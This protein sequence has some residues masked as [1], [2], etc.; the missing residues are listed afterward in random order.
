MYREATRQAGLERL[1][2]FSAQM[3][4]DYVDR[5][6][7][8]F[9]PG[10]HDNVSRLSPYVRHRLVLE[11]EL[12][13]TALGAHSFRAADKFIQEVT[14]RTYWKGWL[15]MRPS[16]WRDYR[17]AVARGRERAREQSRLADR[18]Q[19]ALA[20]ETGIEP[21]D[22]WTRELID[23]GYLHNHARMWFASIW[24]FTL[25]LPWSLGA[26]FFLRYL[27]DG[28]PASNT[29]SWRWVAGLQTPGK[30]YLARASNIARFTDGRFEDVPA[31]ATEARPLTGPPLPDPVPL[32]DPAAVVGDE[33]SIL[34]L[35]DDDLNPESLSIGARP[36]AIAGLTC[37]EARSDESVGLRVR[38]FATQALGD[39]LARA[40][41][42]FECPATALESE[43]AA[44]RLAAIA[45]EHGARQVVFPWSPVG[46]TAER[47]VALVDALKTAGI[48]CARVRRD[49]D[50]AFWP[51]ATR[52]YFSFRKKVP[53]VLADLL[54]AD[55]P[56]HRSQARTGQF[57]R[58]RRLR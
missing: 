10:R 20:G 18:L 53:S 56:A 5:R 29:L 48:R 27:V 51:H 23:T 21:F 40:A 15:E 25:K 13:E 35:H 1:A 44:K 4:R 57:G 6:N 38:D 41:A 36:V 11:S 2:A 39:G 43:N 58:R 3:G 47:L 26:D 34:V 52:G 55:V 16:M 45:Q 42:H 50:S 30:T 32:A 31:L 14:W 22:A 19:R 9:G 33:S 17:V 12:V 49:W 7:F 54:Q 24:I 28:D 8:D 46:P 37:V